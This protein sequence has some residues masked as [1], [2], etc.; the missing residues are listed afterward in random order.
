MATIQST[1]GDDTLDGPGANDTISYSAA[2]AGVTVSLALQGG[3]QDTIGAGVDTLTGFENLTGSDFDDGLLGDDNDNVLA[4]GLGDDMIN[5]GKGIDTAW[6]AASTAAVTVSL[7]AQGAAQDTGGAGSDTLIGISNLM[8]SLFND[9]LAGDDGDNIVDGGVAGRDTLSGGLGT[10]A[11]NGGSGIDTASYAYALGG[12]TVSLIAESYQLVQAGD[13]D[14]LSSIEALVGSAFDDVLIGNNGLNYLYGE[15]GDDLIFGG[16]GNDFLDGGAGTDDTIDYSA[17]TGIR[18]DLTITG[19]QYVGATAATD[20]VRNFEHVI[21]SDLLDRIIGNAAANILIGNGGDDTLDGGLGDDQL[22]GGDGIDTVLFTAATAGVVVDLE[23]DTATGG[24]GSDTLTDIENATGTA[25]NDVLTGCGCDNRLVG[26]AGNDHVEG[27]A[28]DDIMDG[29]AGVDTLSFASATDYV[30][31]DLSLLTQQDTGDGFDTFRGFENLVGSAYD[32]ELYGSALDNDI[33]GG[34]GFDYISGGGRN[35][36]LHGGDDD[37]DLSG[38]NGNDTLMGD[39]GDDYLLGGVGNDLLFG[40]DGSDTAVYA[41]SA[42]RVSVDLAIA[43]QQYTIGQGYDT[44]RGIEN[45][46]GSAFDDK[47]YGDAGANEITGFFGGDILTGRAGADIFVYETEFDSGV[48]GC[49][50][51]DL[52]TDFTAEDILDL[53]AVDADYYTFA[54]DA[55]V[56]VASLSGTAGE[57]VLSYDAASNQT[58][59]EADTDGDGFGDF[60]FVFTGDVTGLTA[61]WV[62]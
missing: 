5:G 31:V 22:F 54:D 6:Y 44:L 34:A 3:A 24:S 61:T 56:Q 52:I 14:R 25:F 50:G 9:V 41:E 53:S 27:G 12:V 43:T 48:C 38:D 35:D 11:I 57:F 8:G 49:Y 55:F 4:G 1:A 13:S 29:G 16:G 32:D 10:D 59:F 23:A 21:G 7:V 39:L 15:G 36:T 17:G 51:T 20:T 46:F 42:G 40:G 33:Q 26:G 18:L 45:L 60:G 58:L 2:T 47:L 19:A 28:G 30:T 62:L 37:D